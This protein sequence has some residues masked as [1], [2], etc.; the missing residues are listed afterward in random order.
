MF[1]SQSSSEVASALGYD[2]LFL[3]FERS[4]DY[5]I[6]YCTILFSHD[7]F[8]SYHQKLSYDM[9]RFITSHSG[10][11]HSPEELKRS[12]SVTDSIVHSSRRAYMSDTV[13]ISLEK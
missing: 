13:F 3:Y 1:N 9:P 5:T 10:R 7:G 2:A 11:A 6:L 4:R 12:D 8:F